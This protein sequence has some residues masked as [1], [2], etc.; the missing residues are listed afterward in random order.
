MAT[1]QKAKSKTRA[2]AK[3]K[4]KATTKAKKKAPTK[5]TTPKPTAAV[6]KRAVA[7]LAALKREH[8]DAHC[9]LDFTNGLELLIGT[10]LA[11][12]CTDARVNIVTKSLFKKYRTPKDYLR[13]PDEDLME[14]IH[15]TGFFRNKTK[16]IK[17]ACASIIENFGGKIPDNMDDLLK[18]AGVG[19][20]TANCI[21]ANVFNVPGVVVDTHM[22]RLSRRMGF[23]DGDD[24]TRVEFEMMAIVPESGWINL[25]HLIPWHGRRVCKARKPSCDTCAIDDLCPK[26]I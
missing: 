5:K 26:L 24:A 2:K 21:L 7:I 4:I 10:I 22:L 9:E 25:S 14:A 13:A 17:K 15:S 18:L 8:P 1:K 11:A 20:K 3:T 23:T 6:R 16:S 19:R 12:Q